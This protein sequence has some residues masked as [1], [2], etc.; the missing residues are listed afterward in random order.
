MIADYGDQVVKHDDLAHTGNRFGGLMIDLTDRTAEYGTGRQCRELD[1]LRHR[2]DAI[3]AR[4]HWALSGVSR[5][6]SG[7]PMSLNCSFVFSF[8]PA[9]G[10]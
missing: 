7:L 3:S 9:G 5:R 4:G 8:G 6:L 1:S 10:V 2:I